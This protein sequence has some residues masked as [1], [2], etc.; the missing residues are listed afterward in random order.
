MRAWV[1]FN[2]APIS[3]GPG[4]ERCE[5]SDLFILEI[6]VF[7]LVFE[8]PRSKWRGSG[9]PYLLQNMIGGLGWPE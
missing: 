1:P 2:T 7:Y 6:A 9:F 4:I 3:A 5:Y 8:C